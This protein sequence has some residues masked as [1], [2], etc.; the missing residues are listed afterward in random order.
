MPNKGLA[1]CPLRRRRG[2]VSS[3]PSLSRVSTPAGDDHSAAAAALRAVPKEE[4]L[5]QSVVGHVVFPEYLPRSATFVHTAIRSQPFDAVVFTDRVANLEEFPAR[6]VVGLSTG[7]DV[8][9]GAVSRLIGRQARARRRWDR[10]LECAVVE[11][12]CSVLHA[13]FGWSGKISVGVSRRLGVPLLVTFYGRDLSHR[14]PRLSR[15]GLYDSLFATA[16]RVLCEGPVLAARLAD[17]GCPPEK[18]ELVKIGIDL[19]RFP[20]EPRERTRGSFT[21]LQAARFVEKKG[22]DTTIRAFAIARRELPGAELRLIGDGPL[23][24]GLVA[25]AREHGVDDAVRWH[26][27]VDYAAYRRIAADAHACVQPSRT[28]FDGDTEGGAPTVLLEMQA[29]GMPVIST[30]HADIPT[31]VADPEDLVA[32]NDHEALAGEMVRVAVMGEMEWRTRLERA[33]DLVAREHDADALG[34]RLGGLYRD[35][36]AEAS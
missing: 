26:G 25:L 35:A 34:R 36:F 13:H 8:P 29:S 9:G 17:M 20:F 18:L 23:K 2:S 22:I 21:F 7:S 11:H 16:A 10:A 14:A 24:S 5:L 6:R 28:A 3:L 30:R 4:L 15:G 31:V 32:E 33:R 1:C 27:L 12:G 19:D